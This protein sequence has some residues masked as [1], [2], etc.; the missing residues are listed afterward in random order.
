LPQLTEMGRKKALADL[1]TRA[2]RSTRSPKSTGAGTPAKVSD[3]NAAAA[4]S[5]GLA[6]RM[7]H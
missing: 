5:A 3:G 4:F 6:A 7:S 2:Q 1:E